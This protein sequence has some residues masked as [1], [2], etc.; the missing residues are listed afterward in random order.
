MDGFKHG[1]G[2]WK[3]S[4]SYNANIYEGQYA[5]DKKE[6]F[7][8]FKWASGNK[9]IGH[10]KNDKREGIGQMTWTD[11]SIYIGEWKEG[12]QH[13]YGC[14]Y[15]PDGTVKE[16]L[17]EKNS[18][19]GSIDP[20]SYNVP[21]ELL[22]KTFDI[23]KYA[24]DIKFSDEILGKKLYTGHS[25]STSKGRPPLRNGRALSVKQKNNRFA[26][27]S[28]KMSEGV[29]QKVDE[30]KKKRKRFRRRKFRPKGKW[31]PSGKPNHANITRIPGGI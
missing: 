13:G 11:G 31:L 7:G 8:I 24:K 12:I 20:D 17:F 18:F 19:K 3:K 10:Y 26:V 28:D 29:M 22:D 21:K 4:T 1:F 27:C 9:Y 25:I 5:N 15:F 2:R 14:M 23:M 6:G 16:G 30:G